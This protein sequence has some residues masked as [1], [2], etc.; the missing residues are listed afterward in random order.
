MS[1]A[2]GY[3]L[4]TP[5]A[6][7][8]V[9]EQAV[10]HARRIGADATTATA[11]EF[12]GTAIK[13]REGAAISSVRDG[14]HAL[15]ITVFKDGRTGRANT[16]AL[17]RASVGLAVEQAYA[18]ACEVEADPDAGLAEL[19][20]LATEADEVP[21][22]APSGRTPT[23]LT[24][25]ALEIERLA[26]DH[27]ANHK[28][29]VRVDEASAASADM[30]WAC[31]Q[32]NGFARAAG[33]SIQSRGCVA[34]A[35][36][37]GEMVRNWW[38][39]ADRRDECLSSSSLIAGEAVERAING[40]GGRALPTQSAPVMLDARVAGSLVGELVSGLTG[41]AQHQRSTFLAGAAG[42]RRLADHLDL[43]EDPFVP[44]GLASRAWDGEGVASIARAVVSAGVVS[45]YF[46]D[47]RSARKLGMV[48]TGNADGPGNL[49]FS[50]RLASPC[51]DRAAMIRKMGRGLLVT[52]FLGGGVNPTT[53]S[54]SKAAAGFWIEH[55]S[56]AYPVR[57]ITIAGALPDMLVGIVSVGQDVYRQGAIGTGSILIDTMRIAGR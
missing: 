36:R 5:E 1:A 18:I 12:A 35:T 30:Y 57:D 27:A 48:P 20:W 10:V 14:G 45:G 31:V 6:L 39:S 47:A 7:L 4:Q 13:V 40:L 17:D 51:D 55:G 29:S 19:A 33:A 2:S 28:A 24:D 11:N 37:D 53:G 50:S 52:E 34:I 42:S 22:F 25:V 44:F 41:H 8:E 54:Y 32:S 16:E 21:L 15:A 9:A 23:M 56:I 38:H 49:T 26:I 3:L 43:M 46:L